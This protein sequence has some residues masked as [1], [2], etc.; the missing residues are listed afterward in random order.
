MRKRV[1]IVSP[2]SVGYEGGASR[3][4]MLT[5]EALRELGYH[6]TIFSIKDGVSFAKNIRTVELDDY[7][8]EYLKTVSGEI[9]KELS[10]LRKYLLKISVTIL[11]E[12]FDIVQIHGVTRVAPQIAAFLAARMTRA[13]IVYIYHD[14]L[15]EGATLTRGV[16]Q[17]SLMYRLL[18]IF[19]KFVLGLCSIV[20]VVSDVMRDVLVKRYGEKLGRRVHVIYPYVNLNEFIGEE[21]TEYS[22]K[23]Y[24]IRKREPIII[25]VGRL[26]PMARGLENLVIAFGKL[27]KE[28]TV[29]AYLLLVGEGTIRR[30]LEQMAVE[31]GVRD[32]VV[33]TGHVT[34]EEVAELVRE[35]DVA[36]VSYPESIITHTA[37]PNKIVEYM[38]AGKIIVTS[39]LA[40]I[41]RVLGRS[42]VYFNSGDTNSFVDALENAVMKIDKAEKLRQ[43][44]QEKAR[45]FEKKVV[46]EKVMA[47]YQNLGQ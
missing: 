19:E 14:L 4:V 37:L 1:A 21:A 34:H 26:D 16:P 43:E 33:F 42:A 20:V 40:Q 8:I 2:F 9:R 27:V 35:A 23:R 47:L 24:G 25:Y 28:R 29:G 12:K 31:Q 22:L 44:V 38:A 17:N 46:K 15:P 6:I 7:K 36:V 3:R 10:L 18:L 30:K 5:L 13:K 39:R 45:L 41:K 32:R 11:R